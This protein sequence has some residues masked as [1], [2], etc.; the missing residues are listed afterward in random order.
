VVTGIH[1]AAA[2]LVAVA[3]VIA[4][5]RFFRGGDL[6]VALLATAI[7]VDVAAYAL[8]YQ[9]SVAKFGKPYRIYRFQR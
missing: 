5:R 6:V 9:V 4:L 8:V 2:G 7:A 1:L 3:V